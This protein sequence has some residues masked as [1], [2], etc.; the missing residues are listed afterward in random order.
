[1][2]GSGPVLPPVGDCRCVTHRQY[3]QRRSRRPPEPRA[4]GR[5][6]ARRAASALSRN[7]CD[8]RSLRRRRQRHREGAEMTEP[9]PG[10]SL[11]AVAAVHQSCVSTP[12]VHCSLLSTWRM[13]ISAWARRVGSATFVRAPLL[14]RSPVNPG[15]IVRGLGKTMAFVPTSGLGVRRSRH[16]GHD[17]KKRGA[18]PASSP[19]RPLRST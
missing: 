3:G 15:G 1:V 14:T 11:P 9:S 12:G 18:L 6:R 19:R 17:A 4:S 5:D 7:S 10:L 13:L 2:I 8:S 16:Q